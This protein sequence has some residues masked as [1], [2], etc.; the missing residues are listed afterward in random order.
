MSADHHHASTTH[1][2][3]VL[4]PIAPSSR[5]DFVEI[6]QERIGITNPIGLMLGVVSRWV[7]MTIAFIRRYILHI[8]LMLILLVIVEF[9]LRTLEPRLLNRV[10]DTSFTGGHSLAMNA[11]GF[12]GNPVDLTKPEGVQRIIALGDSVTFGTGIAAEH[13]WAAHLESKLD[14]PGSPV[15]VINTGLPA[16]DLAQIELELRTK[17]R[18]MDPDQLV[19]MISGNMI[20]FAIARSEREAIEP[21]NPKARA[22]TRV[23][24]D[25]GLKTKLKGVYNNL[26]IPNALLIGSEHVKHA[27]GLGSHRYNPEFP[28]GVMLAHGYVQ[29]GEKPSRLEDAYTLVQDQL[30]QLKVTADEMGVTLIVAYAPPRF[31]LDDSLRNNLKFVDRDRL[32]TDPIA[33]IQSICDKLSIAFVDPSD[34]LRAAPLPAYVLSD[35]THF[36][37]NG[38]AAIAKAIADEINRP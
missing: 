38:H 22:E 18:E 14:A 21:P 20:S 35:Y 31:L 37:S 32:S 13:T 15:E 33:R 17:W 34:Y 36:A 1:V 26:A 4:E 30:S 2:N 28:V 16:L 24:V 6:E 11:Q 8:A 9:S 23:S 12:R 29:D 7:R 10:Y 27:I 25:A 19:L 3:A 5:Y